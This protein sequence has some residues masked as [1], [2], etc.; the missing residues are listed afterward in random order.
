MD[1]LENRAT[2]AEA[3][4]LGS[5][6]ALDLQRRIFGPA[7]PGTLGIGCNNL[8]EVLS[9]MRAATPR[10]RSYTARHWIFAVVSWGR[11]IRTHWIR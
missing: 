5:R 11:S 9:M 2:S 8:A 1:P 7:H 3:E 4:R 6:G 10:R